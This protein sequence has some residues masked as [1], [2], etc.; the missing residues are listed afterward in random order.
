MV[1]GTVV[2]KGNYGG[3]D[4]LVRHAQR[5]DVERLLSF[6]NI[7]SKEQ[8]FI[9]L[10][11]KQLTLENESRYLEDY[12]HKVENHTAVKLLVIHEDHLI[13]VADIITNGKIESHIGVLHIAISK[14]WRN[15]G[16]GKMLIEKSINEASKNIT[17]L[18]IITLG[19]FENNSAA[20]KLYEKLGFKE[21]G[22][23]P[24]G[25]QYKG[26]LVDHVYMYKTLFS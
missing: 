11:G 23:L 14:E 16:I 2:Y 4:I 7:L 8:T 21:Y 5:D 24:K 12:L 13:G 19:V 9:T 10:Q 25:I 20:R 6:I 22:L 18:Q 17:G 3:V 26:E 1:E 15:K